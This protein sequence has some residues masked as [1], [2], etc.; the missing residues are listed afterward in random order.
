MPNST[1][2]TYQQHNSMLSDLRNI[3]ERLEYWLDKTDA[4]RAKLMGLAKEALKMVADDVY[5]NELSG[6]A[7][8]RE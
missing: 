2:A 8:L 4:R 5:D 1:R 7:R 6:V 3:D